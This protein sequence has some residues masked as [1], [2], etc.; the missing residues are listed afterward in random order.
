M[1]L[2]RLQHCRRGAGSQIAGAQGL[3]QVETA[4]RF[5][6]A[7]IAGSEPPGRAA[8]T[9]AGKLVTPNAIQAARTQRLAG[10]AGEAAGANGRLSQ[11]QAL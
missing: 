4:S 8:D 11:R 9:A 1:G 10:Q 6:V 7:G 3:G 5:G 2:Q